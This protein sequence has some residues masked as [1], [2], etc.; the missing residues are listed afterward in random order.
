[1]VK[2]ARPLVAFFFA[3]GLLA[4]RSTAFAQTLF[5]TPATA[6]G[7][8]AFLAAMQHP[9]T[10][11]LGSFPRSRDA[12]FQRVAFTYDMAVSALVLAHHGDVQAS[13]RVL[14][15]YRQMSLPGA[16]LLTFNTAY[17]INTARPAWEYHVHAG[18]LCWVAIALIR[19]GELTDQP[20]DIEKGAQL[21]EW[22]RGHLN[23]FKGGVVMGLEDPW[24]YTMSVENNWVY[25]AALRVAMSRLQEGPRREAFAE[26][27]RGVRAWLERNIRNRGEGDAVKALDVYTH[28]LLVGPE[29]H[30]DDG[31]IHDPERLAGWARDW[32]RELDELFQV[33]GTARYDYTDA[34]EARLI[35]RERAGWLEGT[36]QVAVAYLTWAPL[37]EAQGDTQFAQHLREQAARAHEEVL[38][39]A[40]DDGHG[41]A[42]PN[43]DAPQP[44]QTFMDGW[45][46]QSKNEPALNGTNWA[47][48]A[49]VGYNPLTMKLPKSDD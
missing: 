21:L 10:G 32:I 30:L 25:Y 22:V 1:M 3:S 43:T 35:G 15:A 37:F 9:T 11:L 27:A 17:D 33:P 4:C 12:A 5:G 41:V 47:Y 24:A 8:A 19:S 42:L 23:H 13:S 40:I 44:F 31:P 26:E 29:A 14:D 20:E 18:P 28:A 46:A 6:R 16:D 45:M 38:L 48:L 36:E 34:H 39:F 7:L 2:P 49:A